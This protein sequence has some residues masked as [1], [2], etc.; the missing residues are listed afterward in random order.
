[1]MFYSIS[2]LVDRCRYV[3]AGD[4]VAQFDALCEVQSDKASVT[5]TSRYD[6]VV[7]KLCYDVDDIALVGKVLV[8]IET[9][10]GDSP[11]SQGRDMN[12]C[13]S[14]VYTHLDI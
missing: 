1:M 12:W 4:R 7:K 3:K 5:I 6:G 9:E 14:H 10:G 11:V 8:E 13:Q 2:I